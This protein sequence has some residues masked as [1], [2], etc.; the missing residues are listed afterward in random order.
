MGSR[1]RKNPAAVTLGRMGGKARMTKMT[2]EA[3]S[4]ISRLGGK[5]GGRG[6]KKKQG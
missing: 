5:A 2:A 1:K 4:A 6:R 3:R